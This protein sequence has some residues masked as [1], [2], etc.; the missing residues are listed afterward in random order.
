MFVLK[1]VQ[2]A[3]L[4]AT[5]HVWMSVQNGV[6]NDPYVP[7]IFLPANAK[8]TLDLRLEKKKTLTA[9]MSST[10]LCSMMT[11]RMNTSPLA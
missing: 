8:D 2:Q 3:F 1:H 7:L 5:C 9:V 4:Q 6:V 10:L 11:C